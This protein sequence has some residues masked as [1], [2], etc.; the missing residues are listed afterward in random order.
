MRIGIL[1]AGQLAQMLSLAAIPLGHEVVCM[2]PTDQPSAHNVAT[3]I[4]ADFNDRIALERLASSVEVITFETENIPVQTIDFCQSLKKTPN[5]LALEITQD[6]WL[7]K[8]YCRKLKIPTADYW[9]IKTPD[10]LKRALGTCDGPSILKTRRFGYDG[11]GQITLAANTDV[12][13]VWKTFG[14][15]DLILERKIS[16]DRELSCFGARDQ[17]G[18]SCI[19]PLTENQHIDGILHCSQPRQNLNQALYQQAHDYLNKLMESFNYIGVLAIE[20]FQVGDQLIVNEMAP[21]VH[22]SGHWTIEGAACSQFENH[23]RAI[24]DMPLG[25]CDPM[26]YSA[27]VNAIS[28][29]PDIMALCQ[30]PYTHWHSYGKTPRLKRKLG[31]ATVHCLTQDELKKQLNQVCTLPPFDRGHRN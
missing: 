3:I 28:V 27:M 14:N 16:F 15:H 11:K 9:L 30:I 7:E 20:L 26:G 18:N 8:E 24:T 2:D 23:I 1:G 12:T 21:R 5:R 17:R 22:N 25:S 29:E 19:Y 10:D 4:K 31:H 6:R 13:D